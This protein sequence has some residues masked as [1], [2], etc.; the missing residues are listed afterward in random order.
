MEKTYVVH[1]DND[2]IGCQALR[3]QGWDQE[4]WKGQEGRCQVGGGEV[5][6]VLNPRVNL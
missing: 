1:W 6:K 2:A 5:N 3:C 4:G